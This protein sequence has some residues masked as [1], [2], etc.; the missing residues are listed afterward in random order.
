MFWP[1]LHHQP[2][3]PNRFTEMTSMSRFHLSI[4]VDTRPCVNKSSSVYNQLQF[5]QWKII[6]T[7]APAMIPSPAMMKMAYKTS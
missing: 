5:G 3:V 4:I 2:F 7:K 1:D 6:E